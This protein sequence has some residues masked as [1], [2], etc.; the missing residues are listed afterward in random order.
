MPCQMNS[1]MTMHYK[2]SHDGIQNKILNIMHT[3]D[4]LHV[5]SQNAKNVGFP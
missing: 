4:D 2:K 1:I 5:P 3:L